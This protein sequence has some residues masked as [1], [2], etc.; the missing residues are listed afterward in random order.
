[1]TC[2]FALDCA[3]RVVF[4]Y[5]DYT[6]VE[7][8]NGRREVEEYISQERTGRET[9]AALSVSREMYTLL[10]HAQQRGLGLEES[11]GHFDTQKSGYVDVDKLIEGLALLGGFL[12]LFFNF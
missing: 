11:F 2:K 3:D 8:E 12:C 4:L 9:S 10:K 5:A 7:I 1:M 6:A